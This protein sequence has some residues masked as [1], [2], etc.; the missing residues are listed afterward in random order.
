MRR[1]DWLIAAILAL[2]LLF[3]F[4][5]AFLFW[6]QPQ[7]VDLGGQ[8]AE[9]DGVYAAADVPGMTANTAFQIALDRARA[10]QSDA[11]MV[12]AVAT[13]EQ[14]NSPYDLYAGNGQ[15]SFQFYSPGVASV[16]TVNV[17]NGTATLLGS[18]QVESNPSFIDQNTWLIDS[19]RAMSIAMEGG[20]TLFYDQHSQLAAIMQLSANVENGRMEWLTVLVNQADG[21]TF[22]M[23]IDAMTG[24]IIL[25]DPST[26][27]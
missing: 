26:Q 7:R 1:V 5:A 12:S 11:V 9:N 13:T 20:G 18:K 24:E 14:F 27:N 21:R 6:V 16:S 15:W 10:W 8:A 19:N 22:Q 2:V 4:G 25:F 17:T 23:R 3:V